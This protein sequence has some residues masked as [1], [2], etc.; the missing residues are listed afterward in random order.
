MMVLVAFLIA[1]VVI[2]LMMT[3]LV[4]ST[5]PLGAYD[6]P[7]FGARSGSTTQMYNRGP[8]WMDLGGIAHPSGI[9]HAPRPTE[10]YTSA[11]PLP[12]TVTPR[13]PD[14][15]GSSPSSHRVDVS[16]SNHAPRSSRRVNPN[17]L[18]GGFAPKW[19]YWRS[20]AIVPASIG[21]ERNSHTGLGWNVRRRL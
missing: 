8:N 9:T 4:A 13:A 16:H 14:S 18:G 2:S 6:E 20:G 7:V 1:V 21:L 17:Y 3:V 12:A 11:L 5:R 15:M 19:A 10:Q